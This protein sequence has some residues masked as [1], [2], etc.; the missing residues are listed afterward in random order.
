MN[1][2]SVIGFRPMTGRRDTIWFDA[3]MQAVQGEVDALLPAT[4]NHIERARRSTTPFFLV[5]S[6]SATEPGTTF[7]YNRETKKLHEIGR[8]IPDID[9]GRMLPTR[10]ESYTTRDGRKLAVNVTLP[11][12]AARGKV[13]AVV[14]LPAMP[15][16][17]NATPGWDARVQF[18][19]SR[20][21]A[22]I[23]PDTRGTRGYGRAN[24]EAGRR[25][26]GLGMQDDIA[27]SARWA[28]AQGFADPA[29]IC[30]IGRRYGGYAAL[31]G[32]TRDRDLFRCA[33]SIS[34][35]VDLGTM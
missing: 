9:V 32:I 33:V 15:W 7:I 20:G 24:L 8:R 34:G 2:K 18:L 29:R 19:A 30:T 3:T 27:D 21:Y 16:H 12:N 23:E 6:S 14:L 25:Q 11:H 35:I 5:E 17:V 13:P 31:M 22:V 28:A 1:D 10:R 4:S 26:W